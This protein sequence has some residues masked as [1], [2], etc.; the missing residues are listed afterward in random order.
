MNQRLFE[1][2]FQFMQEVQNRIPPTQ[3]DKGLQVIG[4]IGGYGLDQAVPTEQRL[5]V[6]AD[7]SASLQYVR[8]RRQPLGLGGMQYRYDLDFA[9]AVHLKK[10]L[11]GDQK[12]SLHLDKHV[13]AS[14]FESII[15]SESACLFFFKLMAEI[16]PGKVEDHEDFMNSI[17]HSFEYFFHSETISVHSTGFIENCKCHDFEVDFGQGI[18][19]RT[20]GLTEFADHFNRFEHVRDTYP[21]HLISL[22][23][24]REFPLLERVAQVKKVISDTPQHLSTEF[25][26][27]D[28]AFSMVLLES[29]GPLGLSRIQHTYSNVPFTPFAGL[30]TQGDPITRFAELTP[31]SRAQVDSA[32][33]SFRVLREMS[34]DSGTKLRRS[35]EWFVSSTRRKDESD[36]LLD[37]AIALEVLYFSFIWGK[38]V[39]EESTFR[40]SFTAAHL[41][42]SNRSTRELI[43]DNAKNFYAAR[44]SVIHNG[45]LPSKKRDA[46]RIGEGLLRDSLRAIVGRLSE[47]RSTDAGSILYGNDTMAPNS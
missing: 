19:F 9:A 12:I 46:P 42:G 34:P 30:R 40:L 45:T 33:A 13:G 29:N 5:S 35:L 44:S 25:D 11:R 4:A 3:S 31:L 14:G 18:A 22:G 15:V 27:I 32:S 43:F 41:L 38:E 1:S 23:M 26:E 7:G 36:K 6:S 28:L 47:G 2:A 17:F 24:L 8:S 16:L 10:E 21:T 20:M 39:R 37:T